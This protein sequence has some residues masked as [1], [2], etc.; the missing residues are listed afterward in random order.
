MRLFKMTL[1]FGWGVASAWGASI[2]TE[3]PDDSAAVYVSAAEFG[4]RGDGIG[5]DTA[6]LQRAIDRVQETT[7]RGI[8]FLPEGRYRVTS[9]LLVWSG[10]RLIGYG[11]QRPALVL[12]ANTPGYQEGRGKYLVHF[13]SDR[14]SSPDQ[15]VRDANPGTFYSAM[16]N[17]DI[18]I[19]PGNPAAIGVRSH[20]AQHGFLSHMDFHIGEGR[21]GVEEVGNES[22]HLRFFGGEFGITTTKPSPSWPF[23]LLDSVFEGQRRAAIETE[24]GGLT[25]LRLHVKNVPTVILVRENRAEELFMQDCRFENVAGPAIVFGEDKSART[26][27]NLQNIVCRDVPVL[28]RLRDHD[29]EVAGA[30]PLYRVAQ[31]SHGLHIED[32][33]ATPEIKTTSDLE[34]IAQLPELPPSDVAPLPP[35]REWIN[36]CALGAKGDGTTD[37]T[38]VLRAAIAQHRVLYF[39]TGRYRVTDTLTLGPD[40][41]LIGLNPITAQIVIDDFTAA[42]QG[43]N[44]PSARPETAS[45]AGIPRSWRRP[46][47]F[48]GRGSPVPLVETPRGGTNIINGLGLDTGGVNNRAVA[49]LWRSG[50]N[51]LV[52]DVRF[53]GG[54]G[55][56]APDGTYPEIYNDNRTADPDPARRWDSQHWSLWVTD[57]GGGTFKGIWTPSPFASAGM[58]VS[59]TT[60]PGRVYAMSSEHHVRSEVILRRVANWSFYAL[61][62]E[63]ER[64]ESGQALPLEIEECRDLL[65]ANFF[66]YRVDMPTPYVTGIR[67]TNSRN[68]HFRGVHV[69]SPGK[70]SF[71]NTLVDATHGVDVR[72]REIAWLK[73]SGEK[74]PAPKPSRTTKLAG[75]F[76]AID[77]LIPDGAGGV[78]F[79]DQDRHTIYA[80]SEARGVSVVTDAIPQP[81]AL[82]R[83]VDGALQIVARHGNVYS[84]APGAS[85]SAIGVL[86][87]E[88]AAQR[89]GAVA[90][91]PTNRWRDSHDWLEANTRREPLHYVA[92][93]GTLFIP[94]PASFPKLTQ[95]RGGWGAG[96]IDLARTYALAP[97]RAGEW[98][99]VAD[100]FG[101]TTWRFRVQ[102]DATLADPRRF[103]EEG[104]AGV[105][106]DPQGN[107]YVCAGQVFVYDPSGKQIDLIEVPERPSAVALGGRNGRT[108][109]IAARSS[110]YSVD[111]GK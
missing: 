70:L 83:S 89:D 35:M 75:G 74:P 62:T 97:A 93:D 84:Y 7:R 45:A 47:P 24:E 11:A 59:D 36:V 4:V 69:Y 86:E 111:I 57:G 87:A 98:F 13:V 100:E 29:R 38:A 20:Y 102:P 60:T 10:I 73:I 107:V 103:A 92:R 18:E 33:G 28:V 42:F 14:P 104:E 88:P 25:L 95:P 27:I 72:S 54:H 48:R 109:F 106:V 77:A 105:T 49:L 51:S 6:G 78:Y 19:Q 63:E 85:E 43:V 15:P 32:L 12:G 34:P 17:I 46:P 66:I 2:Y 90:W 31:F 52:N 64:G 108:L 37:N 1:L 80:W 21:A 82:A 44:G 8:V 94:S 91:L 41:V 40:T 22:S 61:Q 68:L 5:D 58:Y 56:Y 67:V 96:T 99:Y 3:R 9:T 101:Q 76:T 110:L 50:E 30:G 39:P 81:V 55:T 79:V 71:D 26:Q 65:I 16:S 23:V 53:L